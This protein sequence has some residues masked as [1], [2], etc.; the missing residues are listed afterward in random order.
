M[1]NL[2]YSQYGMALTESFEGL[3]LDAYRDVAGVLTIGYGHTGSDVCLGWTITEDQAQALLHSDIAASVVCVNS[4]VTVELNQNQFDALVDF[5]FNEGR[6]NFLRSTLLRLLN[7][8]DYAGAHGQFPK[9]IYA[10]GEVQ[11][12]LI[13][14]R[15][16]EAALFNQGVT[17]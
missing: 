15:D 16:A 1:N 17:A 7:L 2:K 13:R 5:T 3:R 12:G 11:S 10:G 9:W 8:G 4:A 6:G 14:R